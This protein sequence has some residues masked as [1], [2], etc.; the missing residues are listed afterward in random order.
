MGLIR[1]AR[2]RVS[3]ALHWLDWWRDGRHCPHP[4]HRLRRIY[5]D[6]RLAYN[7]KYWARCRECGKALEGDPP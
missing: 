2:D 6:E 4:P 7:F 5:G 3:R 1:G